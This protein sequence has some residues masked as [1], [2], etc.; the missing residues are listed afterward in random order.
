M[1]ATRSDP[2][3]E[4]RL[5]AVEERLA[6]IAEAVR[7][8]ARGIEGNPTAEMVGQPAARAARQAH[9]LL[10]SAGL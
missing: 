4:A 6:V 7:V 10:L 2:D 1:Q 3:V 8:L 9:E 5:A